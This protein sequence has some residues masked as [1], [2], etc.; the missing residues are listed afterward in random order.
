MTLRRWS[1]M[2]RAKDGKL[3]SHLECTDVFSAHLKLSG[4]DV[5]EWADC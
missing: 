5:N 1:I 3:H 4:A 2:T